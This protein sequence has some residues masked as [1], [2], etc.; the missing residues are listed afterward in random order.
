M[1][2][3]PIHKKDVIKASIMLEHKPEYATILAF[4]VNLTKEGG[5]V[6]KELG[7]KVRNAHHDAD[8]API[9][10]PISA[11]SRQ[12][13]TAE[14]IYHLFDKFT[15]YMADVKKEKQARDT[16]HAAA[17]AVKHARAAA[18]A[19]ARSPPPPRPPPAGE[20]G[21]HGCLPRDCR[22]LVARARVVPRRWR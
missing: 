12:V 17:A 18:L 3:G 11:A 8:L 22:D 9:S 5:E 10:T 14:I 7:V 20:G 6:A 13:F 15:A 16:P 4:D 21:A 1:N 19:T 2:I